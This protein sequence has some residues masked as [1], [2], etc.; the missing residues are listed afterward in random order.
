MPM[1]IVAS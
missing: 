1:H